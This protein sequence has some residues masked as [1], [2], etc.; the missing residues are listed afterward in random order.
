MT[1]SL[2]LSQRRALV[3]GASRG[4]GAAV[5]DILSSAGADLVLA[6]SRPSPELEAVTALT[7]DRGVTV[8]TVTGDVSLA[9]TA[10]RCVETAR[11]V[12]G[13]LDILVNNAGIWEGSAI[14]TLDPA[15]L[16]RMLGVNLASVFHLCRAATPLLRDSPA[17]RIVNISSTASLMGEPLHAAYA[18]SK[19]GVDAL[20]R[21]LAVEL[22]PAGITVNSVAPGWTITEMTRDE[23]D[24]DAGRKLVASIPLRK[25]ATSMDVAQAVVFLA[26]DWAGHVSGVTL[27]VEGAYRI[28]R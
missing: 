19:G 4:I 16:D 18:A 17:G 3:T 25:A 8:A 20:T 10:D 28:R 27:P 2:D 14:D 6:A 12:L 21:S 22:G 5:A 26:S 1:L 15:D 7:R 11:D 9:D 23:L 24:T 13:G